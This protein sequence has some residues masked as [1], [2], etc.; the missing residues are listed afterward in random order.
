MAA[1]NPWV[2]QHAQKKIEEAQKCNFPWIVLERLGLSE[3]PDEL[4]NL[5]HL[6]ELVVIDNLLTTVPPKISNLKNLKRLNL[7]YNQLT[8]LPAEIGSLTNLTH[9]DL[10]C[11][12]LSAL[13]KE[14]ANLK[15]LEY[16][17]LRFNQLPISEEILEQV[18]NPSLIIQEYLNNLEPA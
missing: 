2:I 17:D 8:E 12:N 4:F 16:L 6:K 15:N 1:Y 5:T 7:F 11:N 14:I 13:P 3:I 9:L 10:S 18:H